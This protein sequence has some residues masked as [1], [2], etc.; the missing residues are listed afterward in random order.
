MP[1]KSLCMCR[2]TK[3][4]QFVGDVSYPLPRR[5]LLVLEGNSADMTKHCIPSVKTERISITFR[6][7]QVGEWTMYFS[8][9]ISEYMCVCVCVRVSLYLSLSL[10]VS[11]CLRSI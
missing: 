2:V 10:N 4:G 8:L 7:M 3:P 11:A 9:Y 6:R 5:S 1:F